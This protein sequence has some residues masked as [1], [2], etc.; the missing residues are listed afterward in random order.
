MD[1]LQIESVIKE[2]SDFNKKAANKVDNRLAKFLE[3]FNNE[4]PENSIVR[5]KAET[6]TWAFLD[7]VLSL[8]ANGNNSSVI[9]EIY[10]IIEKFAIRDLPKFLSRNKK[11]QSIITDL[12]ERKNL[13]EIAI[14][15]ERIGIWSD[16]DLINIKQITKIRNGIAHKSEKLI[17]KALNSGKKTHFLEIDSI[18]KEYDSSQFIIITINL[19]LKIIFNKKY[20]NNLKK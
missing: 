16:N 18:V 17:A 19:L 9:I 13:N 10:S 1:E 2:V 5:F 15:F 8:Y 20:S 14:F 6:I 11:V 12:I 4:F 3:L 7:T